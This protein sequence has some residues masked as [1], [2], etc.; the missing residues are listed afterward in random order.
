[1]EGGAKGKSQRPEDAG[2][3]SSSKGAVG[4]DEKQEMEKFCA[5][6][7]SIRELRERRRQRAAA[8]PPTKRPKVVQRSAP[9]TPTFQWEDFRGVADLEKDQAAIQGT[10]GVRQEEREQEETSPE[11]HLSL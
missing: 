6:L 4:E 11:L 8:E 5:L 9:W 7:K 1:M 10:S 3:V 2:G